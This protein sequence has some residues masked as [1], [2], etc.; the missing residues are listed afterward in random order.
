MGLTLLTERYVNQIAAKIFL[1]V[2]RPHAERLNNLNA[3]PSRVGLG[4]Y[5]PTRVYRYFYAK[6]FTRN[7]A[8]AL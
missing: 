4:G 1:W 8:I 7:G 6:T 2:A 5:E 3:Q